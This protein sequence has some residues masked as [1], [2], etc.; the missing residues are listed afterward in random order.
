MATPV[1]AIGSVLLNVTVATQAEGAEMTA[2]SS[3]HM[4]MR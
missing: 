1:I 4:A 3:V 2:H